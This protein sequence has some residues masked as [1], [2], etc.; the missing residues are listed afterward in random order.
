MLDPWGGERLPP[1]RLLELGDAGAVGRC[2]PGASARRSCRRCRQRPLPVGR[3]PLLPRGAGWRLYCAPMTD[4]VRYL[5]PLESDDDSRMAHVWAD[6]FAD[7]V[8]GLW[9]AGRVLRAQL[10]GGVERR[11]TGRCAALRPMP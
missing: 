2:R 8:C 5:L 4:D 7:T 9:R 1:T 11:A 3:G 6:D 10:R